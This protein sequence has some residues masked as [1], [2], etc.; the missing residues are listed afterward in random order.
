MPVHT[1]TRLVTVLGTPA[2]LPPPGDVDLHF[3]GRDGTRYS[4]ELR[5]RMRLST[6]TFARLVCDTANK[7]RHVC[8]YLVLDKPTGRLVQVHPAALYSA[9]AGYLD[10][11]WHPANDHWWPDVPHRMYWDGMLY[12][13]FGFMP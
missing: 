8:T 1:K 6:L 12:D 10:P 2:H 5:L 3:C 11:S 9:V 13:L 7:D 4:Y